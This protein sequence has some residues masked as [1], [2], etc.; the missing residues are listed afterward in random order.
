METN[1]NKMLDKDMI[2]NFENIRVFV[3]PESGGAGVIPFV[4]IGSAIVLGSCM[5]YYY[6]FETIKGKRK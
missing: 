2:A 4:I 6:Y 1:N 5:G 3:L